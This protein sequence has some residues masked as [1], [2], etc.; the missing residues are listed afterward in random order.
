LPGAS[1]HCAR[2]RGG[3]I[4]ATSENRLDAPYAQGNIVVGQAVENL[5]GDAAGLHQL[6]ATQLGPGRMAGIKLAA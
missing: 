2:E 1:R 4:P 5:F 3:D 6:C